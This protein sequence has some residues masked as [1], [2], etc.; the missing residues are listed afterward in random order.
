MSV[1]VVYWAELVDH[2]ETVHSGI[3]GLY[4]TKEHAEA[5][6]EQAEQGMPFAYVQIEEVGLIDP[7]T[8]GKL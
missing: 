1:W 8:E 5:A 2:N 7:G 6:F 4:K 3:V